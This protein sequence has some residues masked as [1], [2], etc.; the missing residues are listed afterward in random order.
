MSYRIEQA[1]T[2]AP[3]ASSPDSA[4]LGTTSVLPF[5]QIVTFCPS[6]GGGGGGAGGAGAGG[7]GAGA[8]G[9]GGAV[10]GG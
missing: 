1:P 6:T 10:G 9:G 8:A 2:V 4:L 5:R 7:G 3:A